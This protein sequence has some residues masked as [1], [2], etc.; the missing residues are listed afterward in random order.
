MKIFEKRTDSEYIKIDYDH[1]FKV[2][3][4]RKQLGKIQFDD[5]K[6]RTYSNIPKH[7]I[8]DFLRKAFKTSPWLKINKFKIKNTSDKEYHIDFI[9]WEYSLNGYVLKMLYHNH[10]DSNDYS[11]KSHGVRII[12]NINCLELFDDILDIND[13]EII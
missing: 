10:Y 9:Y 2:Y 1:Y 13:V 5:A 8:F 3:Q 4:I 11:K 7:K 12:K 6:K